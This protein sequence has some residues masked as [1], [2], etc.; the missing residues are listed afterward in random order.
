MRVFQEVDLPPTCYVAEVALWAALGRV[1]RVIVKVSEYGEDYTTTDP[2]AT[3]AAFEEDSEILSYS[4]PFTEA[5]FRKMGVLVDF[6]R[7]SRIKALAAEWGYH[8]VR[9]LTG[10]E[11]VE[12]RREYIRMIN[13]ITAEKTGKTVS[14]PEDVF[15][16]VRDHVDWASAI[17]SQC[18][19]VID[20]ARAVVYRALARGQLTAKAWREA[21]DQRTKDSDLPLIDVP[22]DHWSLRHFDWETS[23]LDHAESSYFAVQVPTANMLAVFPQPQCDPDERLVSAYPGC[24]LF[25]DKSESRVVPQFKQKR[26]GPPLQGNLSHRDMVFNFARKF[27]PP[28]V[29]DKIYIGHVQSALE[30]V[31]GLTMPPQTIRDHLA[32][33]RLTLGGDHRVEQRA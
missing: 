28:P 23:T 21:P 1:P 5:E 31:G 10:D 8:S 20:E 33:Y 17:D 7:Y 19:K 29:L 27:P 12:K 6:D 32:A 26:R 16:K 30:I 15:A 24:L 18:D 4:T 22:T 13:I 11:V 3:R 2:R 9:N 25:D 14:I